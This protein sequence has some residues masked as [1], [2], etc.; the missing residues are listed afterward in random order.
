MVSVPPSRRN[1]STVNWLTAAAVS[2]CSASGDGFWRE[3]ST[4]SSPSARPTAARN[5][6]S[7]TP[8]NLTA[9]SASPMPGFAA[10]CETMRSMASSE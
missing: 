7:F 10:R 5:S 6:A 3:R 9:A 8:P 2:F 1:G 4:V